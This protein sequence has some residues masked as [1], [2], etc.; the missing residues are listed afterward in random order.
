[1]EEVFAGIA[2][3]IDYFRANVSES[4]APLSYFKSNLQEC[5]SQIGAI[6]KSCDFIVRIVK[7]GGPHICRLK[8]IISMM[9][10]IWVII[11]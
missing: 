1:M 5:V 7:V 4:I 9:K 3:E 10:K 2:H 11:L 8:C 6:Q